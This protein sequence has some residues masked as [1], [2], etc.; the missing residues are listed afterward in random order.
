[1][2][3]LRDILQNM[4]DDGE[5]FFLRD[6]SKDWEASTLLDTLPQPMLK[7]PAHLQQGLYIA[8]IDEAGYLGSV[9]YKVIQKV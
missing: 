1:M 4:V 2:M 7:R 8:N 9:I 5:K 3:S 6:S